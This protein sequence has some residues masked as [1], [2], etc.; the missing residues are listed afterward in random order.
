MRISA[1]VSALLIPA[2]LAAADSTTLKIDHI[3]VA[4]THL[5]QMRKALAEATGIHA[6]YGGPHSNHATEMALASFP[7][8]SYL[9]LMG[10]QAKADPVAVS[11]HVWSKFLKNNGGPC[12]FAVHV[13]DFGPVTQSL[14]AAG[15]QA[16]RPVPSGRTRPDG[17]KL[18]WETLDIGTGPRGSFFPFLIRDITPREERAFPT[19]K[20]TTDAFSG[21]AKVVIAV[22]DLDHAIS[23]YQRAFHL[24][25]PRWERNS[26]FNAELAWFEGTPIVLARGLTPDSWVSKRVHDYGE[27]PCAFVLKAPANVTGVPSKWFGHSVYWADEAKLGWRLGVEPSH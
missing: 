7:D 25:A 14:K 11:M 8:G 5:D 15:I 26:S 22:S 1:L 16:G 12:A 13:A 6:E 4:G 10:I 18:S 2:A 27:A 19:G 23:Q 24:R 20:P 17:V 21:V 9:E 3:T